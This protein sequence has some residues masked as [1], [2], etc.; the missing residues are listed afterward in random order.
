MKNVQIDHINTCLS[1]FSILK[2]LFTAYFIF[3]DGRSTFHFSYLSKLF[4]LEYL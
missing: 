1:H 3:P 2:M 4:H